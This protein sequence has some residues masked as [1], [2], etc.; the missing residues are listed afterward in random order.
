MSTISECLHGDGRSERRR[1]ITK[2]T[3]WWS[4]FLM[5]VACTLASPKAVYSQ[6]ATS[7]NDISNTNTGNVGIGTGGTAPVYKLNV[8]GSEDKSQIRFG[9]GAFD[10]GGFLFSNAPT[11]GVFSGGASWNGGWF[12]KGVNASSIQLNTGQITFFTNLGLTTNSLFTPTARMLI[13]GAGNVG[14]GTSLPGFRVDV[15]GGQVNASGGLCINGDCKTAWSQVGGGGSSQWTTSGSTIFYNAG[16][17][18]IGTSGAPTRRLEVLG[19][20][21]FHQYSTT[22]G[23]EYGVYTSPNN[24]HFSSNLYF[25]GQW[26]MI[27][28]GKGSAISIGPNNNNQ[29]FAIWADN[30]SRAANATSSLT[31]LLGLTMTGNLGVGIGTPDALAKLHVYGSGPFGQDIQTTTNDWTRLRFVTPNRTW[32]FFLDGG[33]AGLGTG[34]LGLYDYTAALWRMVFDTTGKVGIGITAPLYSLDV[35]GGVNGFRAKAA[36]T[37]SADAVAVFENNSAVQMIVRGNG[38]VGIGTSTPNAAYKLDVQ[39]GSINT[40]G[41]LCIAG[42]CKSDWSQV[43]GTSQWTTAG[44]NIHY[45]TGN[46]GLGASSPTEKLEIAG[47]LKLT[48]TGNITA[49]GTIEGGNIKAKYQDVAEWVDSSQALLPGTVVVLDSGNSN[50]V[51][52]STSAYD[53]SVAGVISAQPGIMLGEEAEG[54]VLVATTGRVKVKVDATHGPIKIGDL[55]VTSDKTGVA[56]KSL[57]VEIGG[58]RIHRPGTL[59]GKALEPLAQGTGEILVLL[60]LQ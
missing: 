9:L 8:A 41:G 56:M 26:K 34:K 33:N 57:P 7:G 27:G 60:S 54:R 45:N 20:N 22:A 15:Q 37:S 44:S 5:I 18:G 46:V 13:D 53:S 21:V 11:H 25:D 51:I 36:T 30:T 42:V 39:G 1:V 43:G 23:S 2:R 17:V 16:N 29:A 32:G 55:L 58:V 31:Q 4:L 47:N 6:W 38:A 52:A 50:Q 28:S 48:G 3:M 12:A 35:N 14:I 40:S 49:S 59:I 24:N 19:G 10:S